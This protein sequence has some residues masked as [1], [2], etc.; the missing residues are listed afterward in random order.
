LTTFCFDL[1][2]TLCTNTYGDY[3][4]AEPYRWAIERVNALHRAGHRIIVFT[5]RGESTGVDWRARTVE[6][7]KTW[8]VSY[9]E[10]RLGKPTAD[11]F[12]DDRAYTMEGWR[13]GH[14]TVIP[15]PEEHCSR[16]RA[17]ELGIAG[18]APP[19]D[20]MVAE[21]G[22]TFAG[23]IPW[24]SEHIER[25]F[26][27]ARDLGLYPRRDH[28]L[29]A[30]ALE[31][32][33]SAEGGLLG[34]AGDV[35]FTLT[36]SAV[37]HAAYLDL[38]DATGPALAIAV[39]PLAEPLTALRHYRDPQARDG[40]AVRAGAGGWPLREDSRGALFDEL[41]GDVVIV[42]GGEL[43]I[44]PSRGRPTVV[45]EQ[46]LEIAGDCREAPLRRADLLAADEALLIN[47][48]FCLM[49]LSRVDGQPI[50]SGQPGQAAKRLR[51]VLEARVGTS[52]G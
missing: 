4:T 21:V 15:A 31:R 44:T 34:A 23:R 27:N 51:A 7:L 9:D 41:G 8:G 39:R 24:L 42:A 25:L 47:A 1:D 48:P 38:Y 26:G 16:K 30:A 36:V 13:W 28:S 14:P 22:R 11:V 35:V 18:W 52:V 2:G 37:G 17:L 45:R 43:S 32:A 12:V 33:T 50:G 49:P 3:E 29:L 40:L 6:Q 10:L 5:A 19:S 20:L 46:F